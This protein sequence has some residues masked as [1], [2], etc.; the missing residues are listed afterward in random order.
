MVEN[1]D[2]IRMPATG[3]DMEMMLTDAR[4]GDQY[5]SSDL[6]EKLKKKVFVTIRAGTKVN[7]PDGEVVLDRDV[8]VEQD[9][10]LWGQMN[11]FTRDFR[12]GNISGDELKYCDHFCL[13]AGDLMHDKKPTAFM[14]SLA[15][16]ATTLEL[17]QSKGGFLRKR[18]GTFTREEF[19][20]E[21]GD[22]PNI[23][24]GGKKKKGGGF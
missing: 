3:L 7:T 19:K 4:W 11:Y 9:E 12:L 2:P 5:I 17:S 16:V 1:K 8:E 23:L 15:R 22:K 18:L 20:T 13:L 21:L 10:F 24:F 14:A 6:K